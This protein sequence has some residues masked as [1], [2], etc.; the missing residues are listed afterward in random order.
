MLRK[1]IAMTTKELL[2]K[3]IEQIPESYWEQL[4]EVMRSFRKE[5]ERT[6]GGRRVIRME[7]LN[8]KNF[9]FPPEPEWQ[10]VWDEENKE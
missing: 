10:A 5:K 8:E 7:E 3:E 4:L 1:E 6:F 9:P 2:L